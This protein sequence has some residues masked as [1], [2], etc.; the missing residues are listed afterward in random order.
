[1]ETNKIANYLQSEMCDWIDWE[2]NTPNASHMGGVWERQIRTIRGVL[3]SL[4]KSHDNVLNDESF[5]TFIKEVECIV[6]SRPLDV[7]NI[8]DPDI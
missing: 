8:N 2:K 3:S 5:N 6:N 1:M 7:Q 4:L